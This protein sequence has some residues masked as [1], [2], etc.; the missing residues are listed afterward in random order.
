VQRPKRIF[1]IANFKDDS[2]QSIRIERRRWVKGF[3]RLGHDVQRFSYRNILMQSSLIKSKTLARR[4]ARRRADEVLV[5]QVRA[6][7]P[8]IVLVLNPKDLDHNTIAGMREVASA[9]VFVARDNEPFPDTHR[10][11]LLIC[12]EM[13]LVVCSSP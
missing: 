8:D 6:Y 5:K 4:F 10:E 1:I 7:H 2:A 11:R 12:K 9:A 13:D 3:I